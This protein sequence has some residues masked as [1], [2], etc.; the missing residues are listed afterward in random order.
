M[1]LQRWSVSS[2]VGRNIE[3]EIARGTREKRKNQE[4]PYH[5]IMIPFNRFTS[6]RYKNPL[7]SS[8]V[9]FFRIICCGRKEQ[10]LFPE[11][12][13]F[14]IYCRLLKKYK[15]RLGVRIF[16][17]SLMPDYVHLVLQAESTRLLPS[18]LES[19][20][21]DYALHLRNNYKENGRIFDRYRLVMFD[22]LAEL[23]QQIKEVES[24]PVRANLVRAPVEYP[25]SSCFY[26]VM[27]ERNLILDSTGLL[28]GV[29]PEATG[30]HLLMS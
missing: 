23:F 13:D 28:A 22:T 2:W 3:W 6:C 14:E 10:S 27:N 7:H 4:R 11:K 8:G 15:D 30:A 16:G 29:M 17:Y 1:S 20:N 25:Y 24:A 26:R 18:F 12:L 9:T 21:E 19:V 5:F